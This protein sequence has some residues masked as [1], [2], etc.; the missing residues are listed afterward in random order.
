MSCAILVPVGISNNITKDQ[1]D[2]ADA[3]VRKCV[4]KAISDNLKGWSLTEID[5]NRDPE[6]WTARERLIQRKLLCLAH[7]KKV[8]MGKTF[9]EYLKNMFRSSDAPER[10]LAEQAGTEVVQQRLL[11][12]MILYTPFGSRKGISEWMSVATEVN[13]S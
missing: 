1:V 6:G 13:S 3:A 4:T 8:T 10:K 11:G 9:Y 2:K 7:P 5:A 12:A